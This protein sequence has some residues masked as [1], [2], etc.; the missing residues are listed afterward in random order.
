MRRKSTQK[1]ELDVGGGM[2]PRTRQMDGRGDASMGRAC[3]RRITGGR[4]EERV[5]ICIATLRGRGE[6]ER[7]EG[8]ARKHNRESLTWARLAGL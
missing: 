2:F 1:V 5:E 8:D 7:K 3:W 4:R 6:K